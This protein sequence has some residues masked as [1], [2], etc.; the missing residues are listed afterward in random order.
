[1]LYRIIALSIVLGVLLLIWNFTSA[2]ENTNGAPP[3]E[4]GERMLNEI[5]INSLIQRFGEPT[6]QETAVY[7]Y[8]GL[9]R[10]RLSFGGIFSATLVDSADEALSFAHAEDELFQYF[11]FG[12]RDT[13]LTD[14]DRSLLL[15]VYELRWMDPQLPGPRETR[16]GDAL[17]NVAEK[18]SSQETAA[19]GTTIRV[20]TESMPVSTLKFTIYDEESLY[21]EYLTYEFTGGVVIAI[22]QGSYSTGE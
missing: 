11:D 4:W 18:F 16:I 12:E 3:L 19:D 20:L 17:Y 9:G 22:A 2:M 13:P 8:D 21:G 1:M 10:V 7:G 14:K 5:T 6:A 15:Y